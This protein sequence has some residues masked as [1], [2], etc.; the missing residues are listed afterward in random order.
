MHAGL[1]TGMSSTDSTGE[2]F[3]QSNDDSESW[4]YK[5]IER[6]PGGALVKRSVL[7]VSGVA[8][9]QIVIVAASPLLSRLYTPA[10]FGALAVFTSLL[11]VTFTICS[12]RYE[13]AIALPDDEARASAVTAVS[14]ISAFVFSALLTIGVALWHFWLRDVASNDT[15]SSTYILFLPLA[16]L[17]SGWFQVLSFAAVRRGRFHRTARGRV[18]QG[19][20][21]VVVQLGLGVVGVGEIGLVAGLTISWLVA[22]LA[23]TASATA[24]AWRSLRAVPRREMASAARRY[25][26]F[27]LYGTWSG[28]FNRLALEAPPLFLA[29]LYGA[30]AAGF[31]IVAERVIAAPSDLIGNSV[32]QVY[33]NEAARLRR[34]DPAQLPRLLRRTLAKMTLIALPPTIAV[35]ALGPWLFSFVLGAEWWTAGVY[36]R[37]LSVALAAAVAVTPIV[38]TF[39]VAERQDLLFWRDLVRFGAVCAGFAISR[40]VG[41]DD[42]GAVAVYSIVLAISFIPLLT[43]AWRETDR[44]AAQPPSTQPPNGEG[45]EA[46]AASSEVR[47]PDTADVRPEGTSP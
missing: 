22:V 26:S 13:R 8:A 20:S 43:W 44:L 19:V 23:F 39:F 10:D 40:V 2:T 9:A 17:G 31:F 45:E 24:R 27:A 3:D 18:A 29:A 36:A 37:L 41:L 35:A 33:F 28:L 11:G 38:A 21:M 7:L 42:V 12:L 1:L 25:R 30:P 15:G 47:A 46:A 6:V 14:V 16:T 4:L 32:L 34:E 5:M